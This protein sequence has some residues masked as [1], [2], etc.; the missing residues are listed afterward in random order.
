MKLTAEEYCRGLI[1]WKAEGFATVQTA[2]GHD[3][4]SRSLL[5][6]AGSIVES[7]PAP[8]RHIQ[9][10]PSTPATLLLPFSVH[11]EIVDNGQV[12]TRIWDNT[13]RESILIGAPNFGRFHRL[14]VEPRYL[15][16][17]DDMVFRVGEVIVRLTSTVQGEASTP[18]SEVH[19]R[20]TSAFEIEVQTIE[21]KGMFIEIIA[22]ETAQ[23]AYDEAYTIL[24]LLAV[25]VGEECVGNVVFSEDIEG[26]DKGTRFSVEVGRDFRML[27][28]VSSVDESA[29]DHGLSRTINRG[30]EKKALA[31]GLRWYEHDIRAVSPADNLLA[32][33]VGLE[34][35]LD[36]FANAHRLASPLAK[37]TRDESIPGLMAS[38][39]EVHGQAVVDRFLKRLQHDSP[40]IIDKAEFYAQKRNLGSE[41]VARFRRAKKARDPLMHGST[42]TVTREVANDAR[43]ALR[44]ALR[45]ELDIV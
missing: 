44:L 4:F 34:A 12:V 36:A 8:A 32:F 33:Y 5:N 7:L 43:D 42:S 30:I 25:T 23:S 38:L 22:P 29:I 39:V 31:I 41:F 24:G 6:P 16:W 35:L 45:T 18:I 9:F 37:I 2:S 21:R 15:S 27:R 20:N 17:N 40:S 10:S 3:S 1:S 19:E 14:V 28:T 26:T 13:L 11:W